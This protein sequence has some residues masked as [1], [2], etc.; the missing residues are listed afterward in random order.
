MNHTI[1]ER[2]AALRAIMSKKGIQAFI[3]PGTDPHLSEYSAE[4]W[5]S[6]DWISGFTGSA[7]TAV[8]T[9][10]QA[11]L[12]TDSRYFLQAEIQLEGTSFKLFK[13]GL[14]ETPDIVSW[15]ISTLP[16]GSNVAI[17]GAMFATTEALQL[18]KTLL[19]SDLQLI[20]DFDPFDKIWTN[21]PVIPQ[22]P[23]FIYEEKYSGESTQSKIEKILSDINKKGASAI[24]LSALDEIAWAFNVRGTDVECN[25]VVICYA[26]ISSSR[27]ALFID[28]AKVPQKEYDCLTEQGIEV[29][30][31]NKVL[32]FIEQIPQNITLFIDAGK[33]NFKLFQAVSGNKKY[34]MGNSPVTW[35]K[36]LKNPTE[37]E[38]F[39]NAM[40][41]DGVAL[42]QF[43]RWL[44]AHISDGN[45]TET[46]IGRQ[47]IRFRSKQE[48]FIGESFSTISGYNGHGAIVHYHATPE[49]ESTLEPSGFLLIDSGGQY[50]DGTTD[51]T[52]TIA[53]GAL[54]E[55]QKRDYTL[56]LK[57]HIAIATCHFPK[58]TRGSQIDV[59]AR[60]PLWDYGM[61]Y[62]HG[63][64]HGIGHFLNVHEGPQNIRLEEN[65][66]PLTPG[67]VTSN[68]PGVY[69]T[70][71]YGIRTE[72][73][74][75]TTFDKQTDFAEFYKFETLTLCPIDKKG[76]DISLLTDAEISWL[77]EYHQMVF[78]KLSPKLSDEETIWLKQATAPISR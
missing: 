45:I 60:K 54:T 38:G 59:L 62:L 2:L 66:T 53:L 75:L 31:Y 78:D 28:A 35:L 70:D 74:V 41:K 49:S 26:Y 50:L 15:L 8:V 22:N 77:N 44:E 7:G 10:D 67:M 33:L 63:T 69:I 40:I 55:R 14:P 21:R 18:Q 39:R 34:I 51:I 27:K 61:G 32:P 16:V 3:I 30:P 12:W 57:G 76:I 56:V 1:I 36:S 72:N 58:G 25:P 9:F 71:E 37:I 24:L 43:F 73:L 52:R 19:Q 47:L 6:R 13:Q 29:I 68:E 65:P 64:G 42:V 46:E 11:G 48:L 23:L 17:D 4:H 20:A 5:K